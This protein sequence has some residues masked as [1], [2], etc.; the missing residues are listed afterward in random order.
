VPRAA[1]DSAVEE[2]ERRWRA[3]PVVT[4]GAIRSLVRRTAPGVHDTPGAIVVAPDRGVLGDRWAAGAA[5]HPECQVT[6]IERRIAELL[7]GGPDRWHVPGDNLVVDLDLS[8]LALPV[9]ARL[10]GADGGAVLEITA[11]PH[12]G[13]DTFRERLGDHA[14]RWVNDRANRDRRLRGVHARVL[15]GGTLR[16]R[17]RLVRVA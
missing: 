12:A 1:A 7:A 9:G 17:D 3:M 4:T 10:A 11:K 15:V 2:L 14:L 16:L 6:L 5:P 13:C 8:A